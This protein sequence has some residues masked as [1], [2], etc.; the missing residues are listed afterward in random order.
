MSLTA[1][2]WERVPSL[3]PTHYLDNSI[4]ASEQIFGEEEEKIFKK[5]WIF[6]CHESEVAEVFDFRTVVVAGTPLVVTRGEDGQIRTFL[7]ICSHRGAEVVREPSGNALSFTCL[8]HL[9]SYDTMGNCVS[10]TRDE[11][12]E[13]V[14]IRKEDMGLREIRTEVR[15]GLVFVNLDDEAESLAS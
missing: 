7:N 15:L 6:V 8:F 13:P 9:W 14:G 1:R 10:V 5:S 4:Y 2:E 12:Y 11:A 3:P